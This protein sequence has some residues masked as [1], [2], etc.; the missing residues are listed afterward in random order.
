MNWRLL[1]LL[2]VQLATTAHA[3]QQI[4]EGNVF[5]YRL[6][7]VKDTFLERNGRNFDRFSLQQLLIGRHRGYPLKRTLIQFENLPLNKYVLY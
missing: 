7:T 3:Y 1:L 6:E 4:D 2:A 5:T